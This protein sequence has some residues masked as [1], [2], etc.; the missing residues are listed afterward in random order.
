MS[1]S[2]SGQVGVKR[3]GYLAAFLLG[4]VFGIA[5]GP[6]TFAF[7]APM[8]GVVFK[9][10]A[11]NPFYGALLLV[12]Y[13]VGHCSVIVA[14][15]TSTE[16]VQRFLNWN[17]QSKGVAVV[18]AAC[19]VLV[20]FGGLWLIYTAPDVSASGGPRA[21]LRESAAGALPRAAFTPPIAG[22][23]TSIQA[24]SELNSAANKTGAVFVFLPGK[25]RVLAGSAL[26]SIQQAKRTI[27]A[28][29]GIKMGLFNLNPGTRDYED[30]ATNMSVPGVVVIVKTGARSLISGGIT[31]AKLLDGFRA[32]VAAGGCCPLGES[33]GARQ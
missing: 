13:G 5:L 6:C 8:L 22:D 29:Y 18:K 21:P 16:L 20:L 24:F 30:V 28:G 25:D 7:M 4:L 2:G 23:M 32:A 27:E 31:E 26:R 1:F 9:F 3:R 15:G 19:G 14:A 17:E 12:A 33:S 10:A 11:T